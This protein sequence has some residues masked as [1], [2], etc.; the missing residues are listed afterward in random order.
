MR[1]VMQ[2]LRALT[3]SEKPLVA[4]V[5]GLAVGIGLTMLL[6]CDLV[7]VARSA[8]LSAPFVNLGLV[9]EAAS[10]L[11]LPRL[12]GHP[13]A[14]ALFLLGESLSAD[15]AVAAG[16]ATAVFDDAN[17]FAEALLRGQQLAARPP[18]A[19]RL[20]RRLLRGDPARS[21][22]A[23]PW[24]SSSSRPSS[25]P[26]RRAR[27]SRP[28][29]RSVRPDSRQRNIVREAPCLPKDTQMLVVM[30]KDATPEQVARVVAAVRRDGL[31]ASSTARR[32]ANRHRHYR[33]YQ[34]RRSAGS[35][36]SARRPG[37]VARHQAV[38]ARQPRDARRRYRRH[39]A[40]DH[41][42]AG[43]FTVIA[44]P[45]SVENEAMILRTA[46]FLR[47]QGINLMRAGAYK[48]RT[49]PY[50]FQG[51][52]QEGLDI[53]V[54]MRE[55]TGIGIVTEL[56]DT[57]NADAVEAAADI[58]QI[59]TRNMQNFSLLRRVSRATKPVLLK[60]GLSAPRWKNGSWPPS[61]SWRA[62][63]TT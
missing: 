13:R 16:M 25:N 23:W 46:E 34:R 43:T 19:V 32:N 15:A 38:Q 51:L 29:W 9:P 10:S 37:T 36:V 40:A 35:G 57:D 63:T 49:S 11:L 41:G 31:D 42:R 20:T 26:Q 48:P 1:P 14:A 50:A 12:I 18:M 22:S 3:T 45:C 61:T 5:N 58:I 21:L 33:Q 56:M 44:G 4:A 52:G 17:L 24:N 6:H 53:L 30:H 59:G 7:Y 60:R 62:T 8:R 2:F 27:R 39:A 54:R 47:G 28:S 55:K